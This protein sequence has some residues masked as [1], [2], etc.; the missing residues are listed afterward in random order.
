MISCLV[1]LLIDWIQWNKHVCSLSTILT[2]GVPRTINNFDCISIGLCVINNES[3]EIGFWKP[4]LQHCFINFFPRKSLS[5]NVFKMHITKWY[6]QH[7]TIHKI[8][9]MTSHSCLAIN[10]L[11]MI[12]HD[13]SVLQIPYRLHWCGKVDSIPDTIYR[14]LEINTFCPWICPRK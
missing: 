13:P 12:K 7:F 6:G 11:H 3:F 5:F 4:M 8:I 10:T 9:H 1:C 2:K 14:H